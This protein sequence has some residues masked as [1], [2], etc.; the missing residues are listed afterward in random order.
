MKIL[1]EPLVVTRGQ[2]NNLLDTFQL[3]WRRPPTPDEF[4]GLVDDDIRQE[5][6]YREAGA[7]QLDR[8]ETG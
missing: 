5:I 4:R 3:T 6:A 7:M 1:R 8:N 2:Q